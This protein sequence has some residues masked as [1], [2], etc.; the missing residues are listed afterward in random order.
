SLEGKLTDYLPYYRKDTGDRIT[1]HMLLTHT[2]GIPSYTSQPEF[3]GKISKMYYKPDDFIK[4]QCSGDLQFEPGSKIVYN[5]SGYFILGAIIEH[6]TGLSYEKALRDNILDPLGMKNTGYDY[7]ENIITKRASGYDRR[8]GSLKNTSFLDMSLPYAAGSMYST[9]EDLLVWDKALQTD[10]LLSPELK[11]K[12]FKKYMKMGDMYYGY[13]WMTAKRFDGHDS[14]D[15]ITHG[16]SINGFNAMNYMIPQAGQYVVIFSNAGA[17]PLGKMTDQIIN[18]LNGKDESAPLKPLVRILWNT[19][20]QEGTQSAINKFKELRNKKD[21]YVYTEAE[22]NLMG[23]DLLGN[24]KTDEAIEI[25]KLNTE[26][27]P[28]SSNVYDSYGEALLKKGLKEEAARNYKKSLEL[29]PGNE[30]A[31]NALKE[32]GQ[33]EIKTAELKLT[34]TKLKEYIGSYQIAPGFNIIIT[35]EGGRIFGQATGQSPFEMFPASEDKFYLKVVSA[36]VSF[37]RKD[38][39]VTSMTL[40]QNGRELPGKKVE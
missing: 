30:N 21:E 26:E 8:G 15:V 14:L 6:V 11:K 34:E 38:G 22:I 29:N 24:G 40:F 2:S 12:L 23:Y 7:S 28:Q 32:L 37:Q 17:A 33:G 39:I 25:F 9:V 16:G 10:K 13:G 27:F 1:I 35:V 4:E 36:Q 20:E 18:I 5:N 3:S 31:A 19:L